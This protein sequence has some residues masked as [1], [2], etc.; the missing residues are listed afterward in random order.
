MGL[1]MRTLTLADYML[2]CVKRPFAWGEWDCALFVADIVQIM[3]GIDPAREWR[4]TYSTAA[5]A[6]ALWAT[7]GGSD[8]ICESLGTLHHG[9]PRDGDIGIVEKC[10][11]EMKEGLA[12]HWQG[13]FIAPAL[14]RGLNVVPM[15]RIRRVYRCRR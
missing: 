15:S 2:E 10:D 6:V 4:G 3:T 12:V 8:A 11:H 7:L 13:R 5:D 14:R 9:F 1:A